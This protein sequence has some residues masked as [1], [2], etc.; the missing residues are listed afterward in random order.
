LFLES[1]VSRTAG[2][3]L[4]AKVH[5]DYHAAISGMDGVG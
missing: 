2:L 4:S 3:I 5:D 1:Y